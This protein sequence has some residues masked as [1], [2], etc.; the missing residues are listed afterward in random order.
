MAGN[1]LVIRCDGEEV[2]SINFDAVACLVVK[3]TPAG[4]VKS[5]LDIGLPQA[6]A[7]ALRRLIQEGLAEAVEQAKVGGTDGD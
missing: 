3:R 6:M 1:T 7:S 2:Q 4:E 5:W